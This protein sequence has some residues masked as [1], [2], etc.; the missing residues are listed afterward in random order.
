[1]ESCSF[2]LKIFAMNHAAFFFFTFNMLNADT[3][4][5]E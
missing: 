3:L 1:M 4:N 5:N 2:N